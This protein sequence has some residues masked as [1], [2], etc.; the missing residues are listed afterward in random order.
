[1]TTTMTFE[2]QIEGLQDNNDSPVLV[3]NKGLIGKIAREGDRLYFVSMADSFE[4]YL[5]GVKVP[6]LAGLDISS[7]DLE[8]KPV[9]QIHFVEQKEAVSTLTTLHNRH[10]AMALSIEKLIVLV[11]NSVESDEEETLDVGD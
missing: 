6:G 8:W 10:A 4:A 5:S 1:M 3:L 9:S 11:R 7:E 2:Q